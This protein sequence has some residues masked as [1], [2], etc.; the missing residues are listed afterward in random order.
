MTFSLY[1]D[2][3]TGLPV[4]SCQ[5]HHKLYHCFPYV[6]TIEIRSNIICVCVIPLASH[7]ATGIGLDVMWC[8][9]I[10]CQ[11]QLSLD[12][13]INGATASLMSWQLKSGAP[14]FVVIYAICTGISVIWYQ[15]HH[16]W[17][18]CI[19]HI[20]TTCCAT[21]VQHNFYDHVIPLVLASVVSLMA[22]L[23]SYYNDNQNKVQ[24]DC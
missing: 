15:Q 16:Q 24:H 17:H 20:K 22:L 21:E 9:T 6:K 18:H 19:L 8:H 12:S 13:T 2:I 23:H 11:H 5:K 3:G 4:T 1:D 7:D 14:W 10:K